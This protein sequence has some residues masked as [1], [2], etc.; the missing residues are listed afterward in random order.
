MTTPI[1]GEKPLVAGCHKG[2][3]EYTGAGVPLPLQAIVGG[4]GYGEG[5]NYWGTGEI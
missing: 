4:V 2:I 3:L 5:A 1:G